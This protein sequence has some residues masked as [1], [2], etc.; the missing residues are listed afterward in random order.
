MVRQGFSEFLRD[1]RTLAR[2]KGIRWSV[3]A[4]GGRDSTFHGFTNSLSNYPDAFNVL[5][6]DS[7]APVRTEPKEHLETRD[8][9]DQDQ[10]DDEQCHLMVEMTEAWLVADV[11]A[12]AR[13]YG[14][15]FNRK[16]I[17][18]NPNVEEIDKM[19]L[20]SSLRDATRMTRKGTYHKIHHG[21]KILQVLD[22]PR[23]RAAAAHCNRLFTMVAEEINE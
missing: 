8:G 18:G 10:V 12:L 19:R 13:F 1:L 3:I 2:E 7:E 6:V 15:G 23:V 21:P 4:S 11:D 16:A 5:L 9:W 20:T 17:P 22:V 14:Q